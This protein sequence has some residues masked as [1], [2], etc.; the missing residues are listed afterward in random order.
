MIQ[1]FNTDNS[2]TDEKKHNDGAYKQFISLIKPF[3]IYCTYGIICR[4]FL[5]LL[6]DPSL[7]SFLLQ[8]ISQRFQTP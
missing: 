3:F 8:S 1:V 4:F 7:L 6:N 5:T 2:Q